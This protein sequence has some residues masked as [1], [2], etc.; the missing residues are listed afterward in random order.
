MI[1]VVVVF[2][3]LTLPTCT[4]NFGWISLINWSCAH[5]KSRDGETSLHPC[6]SRLCKAGAHRHQNTAANIDLGKYW[7]PQLKPLPSCI[8]TMV[9]GKDLLS[10]ILSCWQWLWTPW[11][12]YTKRLQHKVCSSEKTVSRNLW[13]IRH[14][15]WQYF[16]IQRNKWRDENFNDNGV[17][18]RDL[19]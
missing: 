9:T 18:Q 16:T 2:Y 8:I 19:L 6:V 11:Y 14:K 17:V 7:L 5:V 10:T 12:Y 4:N 13:W 1:L 3:S 15:T